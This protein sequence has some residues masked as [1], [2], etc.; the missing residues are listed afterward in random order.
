MVLSI[1]D[2]SD[3]TSLLDIQPLKRVNSAAGYNYYLNGQMLGI[4]TNVPQYELHV[5]GTVR[6]TVMEMVSDE[7]Q[8][9]HIT[10]LQPETCLEIIQNVNVYKYTLNKTNEEKIGFVAQDVE[11]VA[12]QVVCGNTET[13]TLDLHQ[14]VAICFAGVKQLSTRLDDLCKRLDDLYADMRQG[15]AA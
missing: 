11:R 14:M 5:N 8:K 15:S 6:C 4:G 13:K 10:V 1:F 7:R 2:L 12:P 3:Y 9:S